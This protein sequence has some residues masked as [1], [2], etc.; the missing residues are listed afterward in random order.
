M[1]ERQKKQTGHARTVRVQ[2]RRMKRQYKQNKAGMICIS[3]VVLI[4]MAAMSVQIVRLRE[5]NKELGKEEKRL[6]A[7]LE[8]EQQRQEEIKAYEEYVMTPE[9]IEQIAKTRL[10]LV[11]SNEIIFKERQPED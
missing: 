1:E 11:Y 9:Y 10:G 7:Q 2:K 8:E 5:Q 3:F 4:L 6:T